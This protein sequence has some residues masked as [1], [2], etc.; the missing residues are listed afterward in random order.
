MILKSMGV[1][2]KKDDMDGYASEVD[3]QATGKF[4]FL[5]FCQVL[6]L[7]I[8]MQLCQVT[9]LF[10]L[11]SALPGNI[12]I[13]TAPILPG[14]IIDQISDEQKM[15]LGIA[16]FIYIGMVII[17]LYLS[18]HLL[19]LYSLVSHEMVYFI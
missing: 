9:L 7:F 17:C 16:L 19:C 1:E 5:Q 3:E 11:F 6:L 14:I 2:C 15:W 18:S 4:T 10:T 13:Y 8:F 12:I